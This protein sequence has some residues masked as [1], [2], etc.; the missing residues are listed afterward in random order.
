[1][2][3]KT[4]KRLIHSHKL[5]Q[6]NTKLMATRSRIGI[7]LA[8][9]SILSVYC[10]WDG[11]PEFNGVK[12]VELFNSYDAAAQLIDGGNISS[13]WTDSGWD[14]QPL[15]ENGTLYYSARGDVSEPRLDNTLEEYLS[16]GEEYAYLFANSEWVCYNLNQFD[17]NQLPQSIQIP[18]DKQC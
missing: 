7:Q 15:P 4:D 16:D 18:F 9:E 10:H 17:D 5:I 3:G 14:R 1:M 6:H 8:D 13:L 11:Y 2:I 12:L